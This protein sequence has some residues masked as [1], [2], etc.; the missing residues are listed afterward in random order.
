MHL[1]RQRLRAFAGADPHRSLRGEIDKR[2]GHFTPVPELER[3]L[4]QPASGYDGNGVGGAAVN[5]HK[6]DETLA[7][8]A[9]RIVDA[10]QFQPEHGQ[11]DPQH[12]PGTQM[13]V[14]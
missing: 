1:P 8:F 2:R 13:S 4:A 10:Q 11:S 12:L 3:P 7:I 14:G 5:L 6:G 9:A